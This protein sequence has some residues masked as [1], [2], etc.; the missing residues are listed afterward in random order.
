LQVWKGHIV[1]VFGIGLRFGFLPVV[2]V[3]AAMLADRIPPVFR[4]GGKLAA[5]PA[6]NFSLFF[7]MLVI[8]F[9]VPSAP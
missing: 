9:L 2:N 7:A 3:S 4:N 1:K 5:I 8:G 6:T